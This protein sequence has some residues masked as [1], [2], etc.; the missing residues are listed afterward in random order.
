[1]KNVVYGKTK[2]TA[3]FCAVFLESTKILA[4]CSKIVNGDQFYNLG[5]SK[6]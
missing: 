1:L 3:R 6:L 4:L 2:L 5:L